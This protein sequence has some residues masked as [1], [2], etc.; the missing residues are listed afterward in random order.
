MVLMIYLFILTASQPTWAYFKARG[1]GITFIL[2][3]YLYFGI[4]VI[5]FYLHTVK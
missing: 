3:L 2:R 4:V 5:F 1:Y